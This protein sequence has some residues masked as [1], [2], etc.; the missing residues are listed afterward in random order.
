MASLKAGD[1]E[2][3]KKSLAAAAASPASF[4]GKDEAKKALTQLQ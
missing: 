1:K 2:T 3:A 4:V